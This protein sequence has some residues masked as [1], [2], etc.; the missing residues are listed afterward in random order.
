M[1]NVTCN[2]DAL[3]HQNPV[4]SVNQQ[5]AFRPNDYAEAINFVRQCP[6]KPPMLSGEAAFIEVTSLSKSSAGQKM[7]KTRTIC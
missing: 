3:A 1:D 7:A 4:T 6:S 2:K 5:S